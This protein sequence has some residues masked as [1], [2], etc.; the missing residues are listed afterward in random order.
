M[1]GIYGRIGRR[2]DP[3]DQ[4]A[5]LALAHRGPDDRG[6]LIDPHGPV[7]RAVALGHT[8]L[9]ILDLSDAGHQPMRSADD[10][11]AIAYNGEIYNF[12]ALRA[13]LEKRGH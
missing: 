11:V 3:L 2:D 4:R 9:S 7:D 5:T 1:C 13:D 12:Q 10:Q 8:R 6:L